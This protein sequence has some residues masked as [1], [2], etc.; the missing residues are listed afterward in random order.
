MHYFVPVHSCE[1]LTTWQGS[2]LPKFVKRQLLAP[3]QTAL[4]E[5]I[6]E[7]KFLYLKIKGV[8]FYSEILTCT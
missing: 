6:K 7:R 4:T 5:Q 3:H 1:F 2:I 8:H